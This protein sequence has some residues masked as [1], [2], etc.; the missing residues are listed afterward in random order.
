LALGRLLFLENQSVALQGTFQ[1]IPNA[2]GLIDV[3][4]TA[5]TIPNTLPGDHIFADASLA[6]IVGSSIKP[7]VRL[8]IIDGAST[9]DLQVWNSAQ[10]ELGATSALGGVCVI[11]RYTVVTGGTLTLKVRAQDNFA[12]GNNYE[13]GGD[14]VTRYQLFR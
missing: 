5:I 13:I 1:N 6:F 4:G 10:F 9:V 14:V 12:T 7:E 8:T 2:S 11:G 3:T